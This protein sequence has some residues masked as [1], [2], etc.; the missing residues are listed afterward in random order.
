MSFPIAVQSAIFW[1]LSCTPCH[2]VLNRHKTKRKAKK[3]SEEKARVITEQPHIYQNPDPFETNPYWAEE[4][5]M[6]PSLPKKGKG[7]DGFSKAT[8]QRGLANG[9]RDLTSV[10]T[11]SSIAITSPSRT[12]SSMSPKTSNTPAPTNMN[13]IGSTP[14]VVASEED[15]ASAVLSKT[16]SVSTGSDWNF[17]RYQR[18]DEELWGYEFSRTGQKLMDAIKQ[19]R[20]TAGRYV[21]SKLG[22]EKE[23]TAEDRHNFYFSPKNPPVNDYHP[24]VVSSKP[25]HRDALRWMLQPPPPAKVMEGKT[26]VGRTSSGSRRRVGT[27][28]GMSM[29]RR[30]GE[31]A[32]EA[33]RRNGE[34][35]FE[36]GELH[37]TS[38]L[39]RARHRQS[40]VSSTRTKTGRRTRS[41]SISTESDDSADDAYR[42]RRRSRRYITTPEPQPGDSEDEYISRSLESLSNGIHSTYAAQKPRL[43]TI[44]SS[45]ST[46]KVST[47]QT[48]E[49]SISREP[50]GDVTNQAPTVV[51]G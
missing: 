7:G 13:G 11:E 23:V 37:S 12:R 14:T 8:S 6:G 1:V 25:I 21:E 33:R 18:E 28:D 49:T 27:P 42:R 10:G 26:P 45:E 46:M 41:Y 32:L 51:G 2:Q 48:N 5:Q 30:V 36:E 4:I 44:L 43:P 24:P 15:A 19:A 34:T 3:E 47:S 9:S 16:V 35:P 50:L 38:S 22:L 29:G 31:R 20:T 40:T 17:K 39:N